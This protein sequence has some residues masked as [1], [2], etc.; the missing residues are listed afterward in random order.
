MNRIALSFHQL[1]MDGK[2]DSFSSSPDVFVYKED[3]F[4]AYG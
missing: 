1:L 4:N 3:D 2:N